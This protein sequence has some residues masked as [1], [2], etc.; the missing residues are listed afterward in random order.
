MRMSGKIEGNELKI[1][2]E[3]NKFYQHTSFLL[4]FTSTL[5]L[6]RIY[7]TVS[8]TA[9]VAI[10]HIRNTKLTLEYI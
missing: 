2:I 5:V 1:Q 8:N 10:F 4:N 6:T 9:N 3:K 7:F